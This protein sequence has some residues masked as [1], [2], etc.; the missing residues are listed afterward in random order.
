[1]VK[2][3]PFSTAKCEI[4]YYHASYLC[5]VKTLARGADQLRLRA[6][7]LLLRH[8]SKGGRDQDDV[9]GPRDVQ[10]ERGQLITLVRGVRADDHA[11]FAASAAES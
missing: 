8:M 5:L 2:L 11:L 3:L 4:R 1:M 7:G 9:E 10:R 6:V